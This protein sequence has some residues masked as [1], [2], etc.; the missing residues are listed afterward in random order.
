MAMKTTVLTG[1]LAALAACAVGAG[2]A[3]AL[4]AQECSTKY[5]AAKEAGTLAGKTWNEYRA[6]ECGDG[7]TAAPATGAAA[8]KTPKIAGAVSGAVFPAAISSKYAAE[9]PSRQRLKTC[10]DQY[11]ANK[12]ANANGGLKWIMKGGG[13]WSECNKKL[14]GKA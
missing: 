4:T 9:K 13:Y 3:Q 7:A 14:K 12:A 5:K 1:V 10:A 6:S 11:R 8:A 2:E